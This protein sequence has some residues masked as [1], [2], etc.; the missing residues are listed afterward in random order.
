M[1]RFKQ[2]GRMFRDPCKKCIV[3]IVCSQECED[4]SQFRRWRDRALGSFVVI[5]ILTAYGLL[6]LDNIG[7][8]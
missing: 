5:V 8:Y 2:G 6:V 7:K 3:G 4:R 1:T